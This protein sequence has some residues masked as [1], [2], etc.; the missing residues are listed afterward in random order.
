M[1]DLLYQT[2]ERALH[3]L[4]SLDQR[5]VAPTP[6][7]LAQLHE[8]GGPLPD[9]PTDPAEIIALLDRVGS[10]ATT[11]SSGGRYYGFVVGGT[12]PAALAA[13]WLAAAWDQN[14]G[15]TV[16]SPVAAA[17]ETITQGWL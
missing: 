11:A 16:L 3:Y 9:A 12:L 1:H 14:A 4:N 5:G 6:A 2:T 15:T 17:I 13:N 8:L 7:A 10:P